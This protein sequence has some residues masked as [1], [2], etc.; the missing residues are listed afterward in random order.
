M[1]KVDKYLQAEYMTDNFQNIHRDS[2]VKIVNEID[3]QW[4]WTDISS[5]KK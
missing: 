1:Y 4:T 3:R 2:Y 5:L